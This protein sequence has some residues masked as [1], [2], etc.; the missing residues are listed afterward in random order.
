M[1]SR[2]IRLITLLFF[3]AD[4][5]LTLGATFVKLPL[6]GWLTSAW[7]VVIVAAGIINHGIH[8]YF[9]PVMSSTLITPANAPETKLVPAPLVSQTVPSTQANQP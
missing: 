2:Q 7:P 1:T 5:P 6:P 4:V 9:D 3:L 8:V